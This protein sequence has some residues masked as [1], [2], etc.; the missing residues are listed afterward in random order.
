MSLEDAVE[1][2]LNE[3]RDALLK[4]GTVTGT[5]AAKVVLTVEGVSMTLPRLASYTPVTNGD[6]VIV[7]ALKPGAWFVLG[8]AAT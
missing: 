3:F 6:V 8:K 4:T 7:A 2:R 1:K 5:S